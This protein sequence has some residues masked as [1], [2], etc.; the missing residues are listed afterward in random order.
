MLTNRIDR[1]KHRLADNIELDPA[2]I[3]VCLISDNTRR[4]IGAPAKTLEI[5]GRA[6]AP[7]ASGKIV[8]EFVIGRQDKCPPGLH[9]GKDICLLMRNCAERA[10][11]FKMRPRN[12]GH[13]AGMRTNHLAARRD[14]ARSRHA[15]LENGARGVF[16]HARQSQRHTP[17][18]VETLHIPVR[19]AEGAI[20]LCQHFLDAGLAG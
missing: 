11:P 3:A 18:I 15:N 2:F 1:D 19:R 5:S 16:R 17:M 6:E 4:R 13:D 10:E 9:A 14:L 12:T 20:D 8:K 7:R